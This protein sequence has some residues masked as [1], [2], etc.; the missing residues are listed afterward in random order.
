MSASVE[1]LLFSVTGPAVSAPAIE[2]AVVPDWRAIAVSALTAALLLIGI[3]RAWPVFRARRAAAKA[4]YEQSEQFAYR[5]L[6]SAL[7]AGNARDAHE[8][9]LAW[10]SRAAPGYELR[11]FAQTFGSA[12]L[13]STLDDFIASRFSAAETSPDLRRL[14]SELAAARHACLRLA[15]RA[16]EPALPPLNP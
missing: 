16:P 9:M 4:A 15:E 3:A 10:L 1:P 5:R 7:N 13:V 12:D 6:Q 2:E 8:S 14:A 11:Q